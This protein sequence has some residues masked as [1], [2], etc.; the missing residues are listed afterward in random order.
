MISRRFVLG[1][2]VVAGV[3][4]PRMAFATQ[5]QALSADLVSALAQ[6]VQGK[7][8]VGGAIVAVRNGQTLGQ[9]FW[10]NASLPFE[11]PV[12]S[13][14]LFHMGSNGKLVTAVAAMQ[15][16]RASGHSVETPV[17][18][19]LPNLPPIIAQIPIDRLMSHTSGLPDYSQTLTDW[20]RPQPRDAVE[21]A[22]ADAPRAF[23]VGEAW[24]YCNSNY[25]VL[26][27]LIEHLSG[28]PYA[29]YLASR[30]FGPAGTPTAR[31]DSAAVPI[32]RRAEPYEISADGVITHAVR[33]EDGVSRAGDGGI[34][35]SAGDVAP[36]RQALT[37]NRLLP[38]EDMAR[39][40]AVTRLKTGRR[41]PYGFGTFSEV[42]NGRQI[43]HHS[44]GVPGFMSFWR[45]WPD[46]G[47]SIWAVS[48]SIGPSSRR[49]NLTKMIYT[50][51]EGLEPGRIQPATNLG[52]GT[53]ERSQTLLRVMT[54]GEGV[55][56]GEGILAPEQT[57]LG[58]ASIPRASKDAT[59]QP[60]ESWLVGDGPAEGEIVRYRVT[61]AG[62]QWELAIGWTPDNRI[63]WT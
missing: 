7:L 63:Y 37:S 47:L 43:L 42:R 5:G 2:G 45:T 23:N 38:A 35:M 34:L 6:E 48:N 39:I 10:G 59:I 33:M 52:D 4:A 12:D 36:W 40:N 44:G 1:V 28:Q 60:L 19:L 55:P 18:D 50:M 51:A 24:S 54:R 62:R 41:V 21:K 53:D 20:D 9:Y 22:I 61:D 31:A 57:A 11:Q 25:V 26:A 14:T 46:T 17:G 56:V 49:P 16:L 8:T 3:A 30:V 29:D 15:L 32:R 13:R 58:R 27:W